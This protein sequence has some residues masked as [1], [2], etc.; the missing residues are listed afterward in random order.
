MPNIVVTEDDDRALEAICPQYLRGGN[1][2][3]KR[4]AW[5][6]ERVLLAE[7]E[8]KAVDAHGRRIPRVGCSEQHG[9]TP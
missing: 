5:A 9:D 6:I 2:T 8:K 7:A 3:T 4:V 1:G